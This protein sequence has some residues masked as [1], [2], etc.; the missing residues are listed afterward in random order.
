MNSKNLGSIAIILLLAMA[1][2]SIG[3]F[4]HAMLVETVEEGRVRVIFDDGSPNRH[5]EVAV[6]DEA[7]QEIDRGDVD[8]EGYFDYDSEKAVKLIAQDNF[9]HRAE[10]V[11]GEEASKPLPRVPTIVG[12]LLLFGAGAAF[13]KKRSKKQQSA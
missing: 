8:D 9:G 4:A 5:A 2:T 7:D 10:Y 6:F 1:L 13:F 3:A 11:V 12:V